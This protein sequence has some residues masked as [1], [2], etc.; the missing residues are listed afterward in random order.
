MGRCGNFSSLAK[1]GARQRM[2]HVPMCHKPP[3]QARHLLTDD[4]EFGEKRMVEIGSQRTQVQLVESYFEGLGSRKISC[5]QPVEQ[6][7][8]ERCVTQLAKPSMK[9]VLN[10]K[11]VEYLH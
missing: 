5:Q 1:I 6:G 9:F 3:S 7:R 4:G 11:I 10:Y 2:E 8:E